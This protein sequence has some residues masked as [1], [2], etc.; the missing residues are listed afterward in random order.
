MVEILGFIKWRVQIFPGSAWGSNS[1]YQ[2]PEGISPISLG[3]INLLYWTLQCILHLRLDASQLF[4]CIS[5]IISGK[6]PWPTGKTVSDDTEWVGFPSTSCYLHYNGCYM[7]VCLP[8][9]K[10]KSKPSQRYSWEQG[11]GPWL[12]WTGTHFSTF[13]FLSEAS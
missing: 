2:W 7:F 10:Q 12:G 11:D 3:F 5:H 8:L 9:K 13:T 6:K 1:I 4:R